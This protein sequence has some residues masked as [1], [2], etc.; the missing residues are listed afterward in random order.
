MAAGDGETTATLLL[1]DDHPLYHA[2]LGSVLQAAHPGYRLLG[3][4]DAAAGHALLMSD[5]TIDL[6]LVDIVLPGTDGFDA[7]A[8]YGRA[9]PHVPRLLIS[10]R[11]DQ[12]TLVRASRSGASGF[13]A[14]SWPVERLLK[15]IER[16]LAGG[17]G[18]DAR[19][20]AQPA[21]GGIGQQLTLRQIEVLCLLA[22]GK[23]NKEIA[24]RLDIADRTV[25]A[26]L[27][28]LFQALGVVSRVQAVL[29][30]KQLG[31]VA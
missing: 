8:D 11:E 29:Q 28:E 13:V 9:C 22:E 17:S 15:V 30:A 19:T 12:A 23:S 20:D 2:G 26:H 5:S 4:A 18:F 14:K 31:I 1:V 7:V 16:V 27:T 10:G 21:S 24:H 25:R 3:A 6:I